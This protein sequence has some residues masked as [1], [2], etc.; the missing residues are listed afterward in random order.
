VKTTNWEVG[1]IFR[2]YEHL[3]PK[4]S[5][6]Q[7]KVINALKNCRT[8]ALGGHVANCNRCGNQDQSYNSCRNRHCPKCQ[9]NKKTEWVEK[10]VEELLPTDY[11]HV[12]FTVPSL[13]NPL[14]LQNKR[15]FYTLLFKCVSETIKE[16]AKN[17]KRLGAHV[18]FFCVLHTWGQKLTEHPH[19]HVVIPKGG[20]SLDK[21]SW[22]EPKG[23]YL[24][25]NKILSKV[26]R[27]KFLESLHDS[28]GV[29]EFHGRI[30]SLE[31]KDL[32]TRHLAM[33]KRSDWVVYSKKPFSGPKQVLTYLGKYTHRIAI[34]NYRI[35]SVKD[36]MVS[37]FYKDYQDESKKKVI[38][39]SV[40]EFMRR[41]LLHVLPRSFV[42]IRHYGIFG[43]RY[44]KK[45][46]A[47]CRYLL[48]AKPKLICGDAAKKEIAMFFKPN[49]GEVKKCPKCSGF[50][51]GP[52][53]EVAPFYN[54]S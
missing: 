11:F 12:V 35:V 23:N 44:K 30:K 3:I 40:R 19:I 38:T 8:S 21:R 33:T 20:L 36:D 14:A 1:D 5:R 39:I 6:D 46:L 50:S 9:Y 22:N 26:F 16:V 25:P 53:F 54:S 15:I 43:S 24:L 29:L 48:R 10:R 52:Y 34:S 17:P 28:F 45:N 27:A 18:G 49:L 37:F 47:L 7:R 32:F 51:L 41:F 13:L 42:K 2:E 4:V 31:E